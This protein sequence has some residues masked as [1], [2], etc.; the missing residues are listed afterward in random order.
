MTVPKPSTQLDKQALKIL[1]NTYWSSSGWIRNEERSLSPD[2]FA[3]AK[4]KGLMFENA[5]LSH[6][7]V[8]LKIFELAKKVDSRMVADAFLT[9]LSTRRLDWRSAL[10][11]YAVFRE[12]PDH[13]HSPEGKRC[14]HC[15]MS[16]DTDDHDFNV[17]NF[18]RG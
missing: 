16:L 2:D 12:M 7:Q 8:V 13:E 17:L 14:M 6:R 18:E 9:S 5:H 10:G 11:S 15:G 1:F 3:C 4:A